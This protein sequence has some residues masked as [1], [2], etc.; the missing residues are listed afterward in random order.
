MPVLRSWTEDENTR[1]YSGAAVYE[2]DVTLS[3]LTGQ[4]TLSFGSGQIVES[5]APG[6]A[7]GM[8]ALLESPIRESAIVYVNGQR[9][10]SVWHPP[11]ELEMGPFLHPGFNQLRIVVAN[12]AINEIAGMALPTYKLLNL[13]YGERFVP[14]GFDNIVPL[15]S[16]ML[17]QLQLQIEKVR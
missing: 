16:G 9:A 3:D 2:R 12:T 1:F 6:N 7:P 11:Y 17:V 10:G 14:Q 4:S 13:R 15:P 8:R 5:T